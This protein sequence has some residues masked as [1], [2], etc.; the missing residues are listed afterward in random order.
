MTTLPILLSF[1]TTHGPASAPFAAISSASATSTLPISAAIAPSP[2]GT[3]AC[4]AL[5]RVR[6]NFAASVTDKRASGRERRIFAERMAGD[7]RRFASAHAKLALQRTHRRQ[8]HRHQRRLRVGGQRQFIGRA[9]ED[10]L[11]E[12]LAQRLVD[13]LKHLARRAERVVKTLAHAGRLASLTGK[14]EGPLASGAEM[15]IFRAFAIRGP[16]GIR[17]P[18]SIVLAGSSPARAPRV[19]GRGKNGFLRTRAYRASR[20]LAAARSM[21]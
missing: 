7:E 18:G 21:R 4:M 9:F 1:A 10:Q 11:R 16:G 17:F 3:A 2:T 12:L 6:N 20:D 19:H 5:P 15:R 8:A 13:L 14:N